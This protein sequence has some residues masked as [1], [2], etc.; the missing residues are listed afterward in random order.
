MTTTTETKT[1][2][3]PTNPFAQFAAFD[4][5]AAWT[6]LMAESFTRMAAFADHYAQVE[7]Q[8]IARS[9]GAVASWAQ[10]SQDAIAYSAQL[11][12]EARKLSL[13]AWKKLGIAA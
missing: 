11:S 2:A 10:M 5:M 7:Q 12:A 3:A 1:T 13:D 6:K 8:A 9:S 4:P